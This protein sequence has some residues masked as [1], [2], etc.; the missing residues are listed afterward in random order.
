M[1]ER[2]RAPL[3]HKAVSAG[4]ANEE[5]TKP[6]ASW[7]KSSAS[8]LGCGSSQSPPFKAQMNAP[9][10]SMHWSLNKSSC[11]AKTAW[12][13]SA[14][15]AAIA[16]MSAWRDSKNFSD[17]SACTRL[18]RPQM[19]THVCRHA[20]SLWGPFPAKAAAVTVVASARRNSPT[21]EAPLRGCAQKQPCNACPHRCETST[22]REHAL[23]EHSVPVRHKET[24]PEHN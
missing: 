13:H 2:E 7:T 24:L 11:A 23:P 5:Q 17:E 4:S 8:P 6:Q 18:K 22:F 1:R 19:S 15:F 9:S 3:S 16:E 12:R 21:G 10:A 14:H 20:A